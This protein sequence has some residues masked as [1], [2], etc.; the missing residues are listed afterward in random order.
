MLGLLA[1]SPGILE[2]ALRLTRA[3]QENEMNVFG[4]FFNFIAS[5][6]VPPTTG[7]AEVRSS[8]LD[9]G[10]G[11][12]FFRFNPMDLHDHNYDIGRF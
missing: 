4:R 9:A 10:Q 12:E 3:Y 8:N 11:P 6:F 7:A 1:S 5:F 2:T